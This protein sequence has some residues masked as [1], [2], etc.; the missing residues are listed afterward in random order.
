MKKN[1]QKAIVKE[2]KQLAK[3][4]LTKQII[5]A[6]KSISIDFIGNKKAE[7]LINKNAKQLAKKLAKEMPSKTIE[8]KTLTVEAPKPIIKKKSVKKEEI[9][10]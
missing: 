3:K 2:S 9:P 10:A 5:D 8:S 6:L 7:K 4:E 1:K